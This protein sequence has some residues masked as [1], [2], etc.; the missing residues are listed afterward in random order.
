[1][2]WGCTSIFNYNLRFPDLVWVFSYFISTMKCHKILKMKT[3]S[4]QNRAFFLDFLHWHIFVMTPRMMIVNMKSA[5]PSPDPIIDK[6]MWSLSSF[7]NARMEIVVDAF[8]T[9]HIQSLEG[10][11]SCEPLIQ[12]EIDPS[13]TTKS[14]LFSWW[15]LRNWWINFSLN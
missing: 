8:S 4:N 7:S 6:Y 2:I 10:F 12:T 9:I 3:L 13:V 14:A 15:S 11:L 5:P 1:M